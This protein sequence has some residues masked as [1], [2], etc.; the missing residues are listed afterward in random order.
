MNW[1]IISA[2]VREERSDGR[3]IVPTVVVVNERPPL[4]SLR[5]DK[6]PAIREGLVVNRVPAGCLEKSQTG[7]PGL[8]P[9]H[10]HAGHRKASCPYRSLR[11]D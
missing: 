10:G 6:A 11:I 1:R 2:E 4:S 5:D 8:G 7:Q 9:P 3:A